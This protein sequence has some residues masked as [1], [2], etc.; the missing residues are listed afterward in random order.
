MNEQRP[1][2]RK[3][4]ALQQALG[5]AAPEIVR[6]YRPKPLTYREMADE[7]QT[8]VN[9]RFPELRLRFDYSDVYRLFKKYGQAAQQ[10]SVR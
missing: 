6:E 1:Q 9:A 7:W 8:R 4:R 10:E 3:V 2:S 5:M